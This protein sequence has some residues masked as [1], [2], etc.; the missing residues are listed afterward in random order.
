MPP[1]TTSP[2][3]ADAAD[4]LSSRLKQELRRFARYLQPH[5]NPADRRFKARLQELGFTAAQRSALVSV[6]LGAAARIIARSGR[7]GDLIEQVEY[8][9]R[10]LAKLNVPPSDI[11]A[12]LGEYDRLLAP[13]LASLSN[14]QR[15]NFEWVRQQVQFSIVLTLNKAY[16]QVREV[17]AQTFYE[18][19]RVE[20]EAPGLDELLSGFLAVLRR[21]CGARQARLYLLDEDGGEWVLRAKAGSGRRS[22]A[23]GV[24]RP[25]RLAATPQMKRRLGR[26]RCVTLT[27]RNMGV[28]L[29][30]RWPGRYRTLWSVPLLSGGRISGVI[31]F[32]FLKRYDWLPREVELL[33]AAAE[34]CMAAAERARLIEDLAA[35]EEKI[36]ALAEHMLH[37]EEMERRRISRELHDETGQALLYLRLQLELLERECREAQPELAR[38]IHNLRQ[39]CGQVIQDTR[40][41]IAALSPAVLEQFGLAAALKQLINRFRELYPCRVTL[42]LG[43][44]GKLPKSIEIVVYRLVQE[45]CNNIAKHSQASRVN[46]SLASADGVLRLDVED[47]GVGFLVTEALARQSS[48]GLAG[49]RE[50]VTLLGG[51]FEIE[52]R[53]RSSAGRGKTGTRITAE[54]PVSRS[55]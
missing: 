20:L 48:F 19:S 15:R 23:A 13:V 32:A 11:V 46:I 53:R 4:V 9:G 34:R 24:R 50:R 33:E 6:T 16:Y 29:E 28:S 3:L 49:M 5:V 47:D 30:P 27:G 22:A 1:T 21:F 44:L 42:R 17:E 36:R 40:R 55:G 31:Q 35:R 26:P 52:S 7:V 41:L 25:L 54:L 8:H 18:L 10:R 14:E 37:V 39:V 43:R 38:R 12:A 2:A 45:C 51:N